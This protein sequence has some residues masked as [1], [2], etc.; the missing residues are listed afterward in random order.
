[1]VFLLNKII[2]PRAILIK[3][4]NPAGM[5]KRVFPI[6]AMEANQSNSSVISRKSLTPLKDSENSSIFLSC[7]PIKSTAKISMTTSSG[8]VGIL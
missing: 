3:I 1:M 6:I 4:C 5:A 8:L 2:M 7:I